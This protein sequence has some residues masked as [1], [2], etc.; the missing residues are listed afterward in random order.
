MLLG[1]VHWV[2]LWTLMDG[3]GRP[4]ESMAVHSLCRSAHARK[5]LQSS[6][7]FPAKIRSTFFS[8]RAI[9]V[10]SCLAEEK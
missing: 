4:S 7:P 8:T 3:H 5:A 1:V 2:G 6:N 9:R 10:F